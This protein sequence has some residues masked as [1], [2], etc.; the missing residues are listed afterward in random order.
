[1]GKWKYG[2]TIVDLGTRWRWVVRF[3][4]RTIYPLGKSRS[5]H[6][7]GGWVGPIVALDAVE[8]REITLPGIEPPAAQPRSQLQNE[9]K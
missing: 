7:I 2:S 3:T 4:P 6:C 5:C 8:K 9:H 1:M